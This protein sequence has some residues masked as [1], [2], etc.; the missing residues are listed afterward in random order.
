MLVRG[1]L[2]SLAKGDAL[3]GN[4]E[5]QLGILIKGPNGRSAQEFAGS[6]IL[7]S[8]GSFKVTVVKDM[9]GT[10][11]DGK[12][13]PNLPAPGPGESDPLQVTI[14]PL[15]SFTTTLGESL[16]ISGAE[17][18]LDAE[19]VVNTLTTN[20]AIDKG[21]KILD[22]FVNCIKLVDQ[23][24]D[25]KYWEW[26]IDPYDTVMLGTSDAQFFNPA[27]SEQ[28]DLITTEQPGAAGVEEALAGESVLLLLYRVTVDATRVQDNGQDGYGYVN[29][30]GVA[31]PTEKLFVWIPAH[32]YIFEID[33]EALTAVQV[34]NP[35]AIALPPLPEGWKSN[36]LLKDVK[37]DGFHV[38]PYEFDLSN[39]TFDG[40]YSFIRPST[41]ALNP[42]ISFLPTDPMRIEVYLSNFGY[43]ATQVEPNVTIKIDGV[44]Y[45][46]TREQ[47]PDEEE[48][49]ASCY[50]SDVQLPDELQTSV[51]VASISNPHMFTTG[52]HALQIAISDGINTTDATTGAIIYKAY[53][54]W[55]DDLPLSGRTVEWGTGH[56]NL[57]A[58]ALEPSSAK[59]NVQDTVPNVG[60]PNSKVNVGSTFTCRLAPKGPG[61]F[62]QVGNMNSASM[63]NNAK[64]VSF[65]EDSY[66]TN[67]LPSAAADATD[68]AAASESVADTAVDPAS[69]N[70]PAVTEEITI[71]DTGKIRVF[72]A[73]YGIPAIA[74]VGIAVDFRV[75]ATTIIA[76]TVPSQVDV[77]FDSGVEVDIFIEADVLLGLASVDFGFSSD[78]GV[79]IPVS[80][81]WSG[82]LS[83][84]QKCF[85]YGLDLFYEVSVL[86]GVADVADGTYPVFQGDMPDNCYS[87][88]SAAQLEN[89]ITPPPASNPAIATDGLSKTLALWRTQAGNIVYSEFNGAWSAPQPVVTNGK[90]GDPAVAF[91]APNQAVAVWSQSGLNTAPTAGMALS[92]I[93]KEQH[94]AYSVW[95]GTT[96]SA[97]QYLTQPTTGDG[98]VALAACP[99]NKVDCP[100]GGEIT[101]VWVHNG[102]TTGDIT[103]REFRIYSATFANGVWSSAQRIDDN[104]SDSDT[105]PAVTYVTG[106]GGFHPLA[107]WMRDSDR[108][109]ETVSD[110]QMALRFLD[111][112]G[113][114]SPASLPTGAMSPSLETDNQGNVQVAFTVVDPADKL[115][116]NRRMLYHAVGTCS[117]STSCT[118]T[119]QQLKD[120]ANRT[121]F[122]E[123]PV[124]TVDGND[125][126]TVTYRAMGYESPTPPPPVAAIQEPTGIS[127]LTGE[128]A[129]V[130]LP[131]TTT[132][133]G[134]TPNY[135]TLDGAVSW[136]AD[137]VYLPQLDT[138]IALAVKGQAPVTTSGSVAVSYQRA[139]TIVDGQPVIFA[140]TVR[141]PNFV[142]TE[143][144]VGAPNADGSFTIY[145][146]LLNAGTEWTASGTDLT[147][148]GFW[149]S[150]V[151]TQLPTGQA[152]LSELAA[153]E[154]VEVSMQVSAP[155][156][157]SAGHVLHLIANRGQ[158]V[159]EATAADNTLALTVGGIAAPDQVRGYV[160]PG[161]R[162]VNLEWQ[163]T[164]D[165]RVQGYRVYRRLAG[166]DWS[167]VGTSSVAGWADPTSQW[168]QQYQY[169]VTSYGYDLGESGYSDVITL[170]APVK[171]TLV[172]QSHQ[173]YL[174]VINVSDR[175][176]TSK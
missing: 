101:A 155:P 4:G 91:L 92:D 115:V 8:F 116:T 100:A 170:D 160:V 152:T 167:A 129:Q 23:Q 69:L 96:W 53:P 143:A 175:P 150:S 124:V 20:Q 134:V 90:S 33:E 95:D 6:D 41:N 58:V 55:F 120:Q 39:P 52:S 14:E 121:I 50:Q 18:Y 11:Q 59:T 47:L 125:K 66:C 31:I 89:G 164:N 65:A 174:P 103:A 17:P 70:S 165:P 57:S 77:S 114:S 27:V 32:N 138:N 93:L 56:T 102:N 113:V 44:P 76:A 107:A 43:N 42:A 154:A 133:N 15:G 156:T 168:D 111:G 137:S 117:G 37:I 140:D 35:A 87:F 105:E 71:L 63:D 28:I 61:I 24:S 12:P 48:Q 128:L 45:P 9:P 139:K 145:T 147:L 149:D 166:G 36:L 64:P 34:G 81:S 72:E 136:R 73:S 26:L 158:P 118:W 141:E 46:V 79:L 1:Q 83:E 131:A 88:P 162:M 86:W 110:R 108:A 98:K 82:G 159:Q 146:T 16:I 38:P 130:E 21:F 173:L 40:L 85:H 169:K 122:A 49:K 19:S 67:S 60:Q 2:P 153:G 10:V 144:R 109:A 51:W 171:P 80:F 13:I 123:G 119:A 3:T 161:N 99:A 172:E 54:S 104:E 7:R 127:Q 68:F 135:L 62:N 176:S 78:I 126:V 132:A 106:A 142:L 74:T 112:G 22:K 151:W 148:E 163:L 25:L 5:G 29:D 97:P 84:P 30:Q 157:P 75:Y 94:L